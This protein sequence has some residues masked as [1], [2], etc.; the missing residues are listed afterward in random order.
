MNKT[1]VRALRYRLIP[2]EF[3]LVFTSP[4]SMSVYV[5]RKASTKLGGEEHLCSLPKYPPKT[6]ILSRLLPLL[7]FSLI[8][9][10]LF[11]FHFLFLSLSLSLTTSR[12]PSISGKVC[13]GGDVLL[14]SSPPGL[15]EGGSRPR[16]W[17]DSHQ[18]HSR[19]RRYPVTIA[20]VGPNGGCFH[21][22][23]GARLQ[24]EVALWDVEVSAVIS[25]ARACVC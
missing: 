1:E 4:V 21:K 16:T 3:Q 20:M 6:H 7:H 15:P 5:C 23:V 14:L 24:G 8:T 22:D 19:G 25:C 18:R 17:Q 2:S 9:T 12:S 13:G 10:H 11:L